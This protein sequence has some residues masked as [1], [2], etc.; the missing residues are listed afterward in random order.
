M[1][2]GMMNYAVSEVYKLYAARSL[3]MSS[4]AIA[5]HRVTLFLWPDSMGSIG[6]LDLK[7]DLSPAQTRSLGRIEHVLREER[8]RG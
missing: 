1:E 3:Y 4:N 7:A 6:H 2:V 5:W 8:M